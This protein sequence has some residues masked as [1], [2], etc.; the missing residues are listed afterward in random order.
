MEFM[1]WATVSS[2]S[3]F[4]CLYRASP[5]LA[6]KN[7]INLISVLTIINLISVLTIWWCPYVKSSLRLLEK[8][9]CY[10]QHV[11]LTK[12]FAL[13]HFLLQGQTCL[14]LQ[15]SLDFPL[16]HSNPLWWK[17]HLFLAWVIEDAVGL[18]RRLHV[19]LLWHQWLWHRV[20]LLWCWM[21]CLGKWTEIMLQYCISSSFVDFEGYSIS[22]KRFL[23][24]VIDTILF[25]CVVKHSLD[26]P[27]PPPPA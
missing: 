4:C 19:H 26:F 22:S 1:I 14:L 7:I 20:G 10:D 23:P 12:L 2:N 16:L 24:T 18:H 15:A 25:S 5:S 9:V 27:P 21:V 11:L 13:L 8:G 6:A 3:R 17:R